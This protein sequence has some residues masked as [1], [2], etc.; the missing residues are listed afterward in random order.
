M[1][2]QDWNG[3]GKIDSYDDYAESEG[4]YHSDVAGGLN[5]VH[6]DY[7][8]RSIKKSSAIT[9]GDIIFIIVEK[10]NAKHRYVL[11]GN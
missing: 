3:D 5:N 2:M 11:C 9:A 7:S 6:S 8:H 10:P 1:A 4:L